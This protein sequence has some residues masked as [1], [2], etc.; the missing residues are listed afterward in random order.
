M[1]NSVTEYQY[2]EAWLAYAN[3][4]AGSKIVGSL[5]TFH[6][7]FGWQYNDEDSEK[8]ALEAG[9]QLL[10]VMPVL[11]V[12]WQ[13]WDGTRPAG[14]EFGLPAE[15]Y[16]IPDR[17]SLGDSDESTWAPDKEGSPRDPWQETA[18]LPLVDPKTKKVFTYSTS[19]W[20]GR[21]AVG[22]LLKEFAAH[23][24]QKPN[25]LP[26]LTLGSGVKKSRDPEIGRYKVPLLKIVGWTDGKAAMALLDHQPSGNGGVELDET[27]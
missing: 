14:D 22:G 7:S 25:E 18:L 15:G 5:L 2:D 4:V 6:Q 26:I 27:F 20:S 21:G 10:A 13:K 23:V 17:A 19:S 12:G 16:R 24:R 3:H 11:Q 9:T 8:V 1:A